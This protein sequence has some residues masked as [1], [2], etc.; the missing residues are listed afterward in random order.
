MSEAV[1]AGESLR[2]V[3]LFTRDTLPAGPWVAL[4]PNDPGRKA[5][6]VD[7]PFRVQTPSRQELYCDDGW[8]GLTDDGDPYPIPSELNPDEPVFTTPV[9]RENMVYQTSPGWR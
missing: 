2:P 3:P 6:R 8:V 4:N 7:G 9:S 5:S 1:E